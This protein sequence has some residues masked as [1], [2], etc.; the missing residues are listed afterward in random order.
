MAPV[1]IVMKNGLDKMLL[2]DGWLTVQ[3]SLRDVKQRKVLEAFVVV[4]GQLKD[5][6][7]KRAADF[8]VV[9]LQ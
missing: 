9:F 8:Q 5:A 3:Q 6:K 4:A 2:N 1:V 7:E